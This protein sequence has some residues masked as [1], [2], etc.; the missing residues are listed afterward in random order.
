[1][2]VYVCTCY[3]HLHVRQTTCTDVCIGSLS[4][5]TNTDLH[6]PAVWLAAAAENHFSGV[7]PPQM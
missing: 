6:T 5:V 3:K 7:I 1:M 4:V 2:Y